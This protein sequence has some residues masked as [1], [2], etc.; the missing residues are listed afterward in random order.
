MT[1]PQTQQSTPPARDIPA[2]YQAGM[3]ALNDA[4]R[5]AAI[6]GDVENALSTFCAATRSTL[7]DQGAHERPGA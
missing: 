7:G 2:L 6:E 5:A 1:S 3:V 4:L